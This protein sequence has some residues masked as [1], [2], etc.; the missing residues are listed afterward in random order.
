MIDVFKKTFLAGL[1]AT[2]MTAERVESV[3]D[4]LVKRGKISADEARDVASKIASEG[5]Q[6][7]AEV[8]STIGNLFD[9]MLGK[10]NVATKTDLAALEARLAAIE[11]ALQNKQDKP[12]TQPTAAQ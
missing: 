1:G 10:A 5:K 9:E 4:D 11:V 2:V 7:Y 8:R 3:L 6:E 12:E